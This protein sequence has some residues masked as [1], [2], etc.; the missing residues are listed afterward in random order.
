MNEG[1]WAE[2]GKICRYV[3]KC[4]VDEGKYVGML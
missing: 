4:R 1:K 3:N 2:E